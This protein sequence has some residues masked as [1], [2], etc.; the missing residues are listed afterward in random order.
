MS[1]LEAQRRNADAPAPSARTVD[2]LRL[3]II[4]G[5]ILAPAA[6]VVAF[7]G[8]PIYA[9]V[10]AAAG[11]I[12]SQEWTRMADPEGP[13]LSFALTGS[14]AA[15]GVIAAS[16]NEAPLGVLWILCVATLS[17]LVFHC[18]GKGGDSAFGAIY[19][20]APCVALA[21]LRLHHAIPG[22]VLIAVLFAAVWGADIGAYAAGRVFGGPR[23]APKISPNKTWAGL[24]G[25]L[26]LATLGGS[27]AGGVTGWP[28][29]WVSGAVA[30]LIL[31]GCGLAGD[32]IASALKRRY[33]V[34]DSGALIPGHGG[35]LDRVDGLMVAAV[36]MAAW[37]AVYD[38][39]IQAGWV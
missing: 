7:V 11:V 28:G 21:W 6:L 2:N 30:G 13:D 37:L 18:R 38:L 26:A 10:I 14:A 8:G 16:G 9:G 5:A 32:L 12:L 24:Y 20:G 15:G 23:L 35:L 1:N 33:G 25:G 17:G 34:K 3:R 19:I 39:V 4:S 27:L 22:E 29:G 31:G 36:A